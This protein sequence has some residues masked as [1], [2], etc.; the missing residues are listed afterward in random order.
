MGVL[1]KISFMIDHAAVVLW[2][3][4]LLQ[5]LLCT[6][7][8]KKYISIDPILLGLIHITLLYPWNT[9]TLLVIYPFKNIVKLFFIIFTWSNWFHVNLILHPLHFVIQQLSH[10]EL[11]YPPLE[12]KLVLIYWMMNILKYH[13]SLI[14]Y[15][16]NHLFINFQHRLK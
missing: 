9:I 15:Q 4:Q 7:I 10:M 8:Q 13:I 6:E 1:Q 12:R 5:E 16:I 11:S 2:Y 3:M 14:Q